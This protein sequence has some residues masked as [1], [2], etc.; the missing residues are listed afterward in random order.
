MKTITVRT[1]YRP[2]YPN[3]ASRQYHLRRLLDGLLAAA[4]S[5]GAVATVLFLLML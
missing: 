3:A 1:T 2:I 4:T 5:A